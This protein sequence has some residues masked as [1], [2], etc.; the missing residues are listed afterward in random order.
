MA[1]LSPRT[2]LPILLQ[3]QTSLSS[4]DSQ[5]QNIEKS[6]HICFSPDVFEISS[7]DSDSYADSDLDDIPFT[8]LLFKMQRTEEDIMLYSNGYRKLNKICDTLQGQLI[9]AEVTS[10][11]KNVPT[12]SFV[13]IK[14]TEKVLQQ[15][16]MAVQDETNFYVSE[17][18]VQEALILKK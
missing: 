7:P 16:H 14:K 5:D 2:T 11:C 18:V 3:S 6:P 1:D 8:Q 4:F 17:D 15:Q 10:S 9:K 13:A 12:G